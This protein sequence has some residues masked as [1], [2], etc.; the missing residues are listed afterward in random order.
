MLQDDAVGLVPSGLYFFFGLPPTD[1]ADN[2][3]HTGTYVELG[4]VQ[5]D[6]KTV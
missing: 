2:H 6:P 1:R 5:L 4:N 3:R